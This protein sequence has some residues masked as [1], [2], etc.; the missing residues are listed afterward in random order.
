MKYLFF[1]QTDGRGHM[2]QAIT[3]KEKL[4]KNGHTIVGVVVGSDKNKKLP[5]FFTEQFACPF[6]DLES[7][8]F[9]STKD[10]KGVRIIASFF[11]T[12]YR[13]RPYL[14]SI[15]QVKKI[16]SSLQPDVIIN[17]YEPLAGN[18]Y[19]LFKDRRPM[20]CLGHQF[21]INHPALKNP[22]INFINKLFFRFYNYLTAGHRA[23][24]IALSFSKE[25]DLPKKNLFVCPPLIRG[26]I[27]N[28]A[29]S[30][31]NFILVY[32][33]TSGFSQ[34][35]ITWSNDHPNYQVEAFWDRH[36]Q[37]ETRLGENLVFHYLN[38]E[39]FINR[40]ST[41]SAY[42]A[43]AGFDS[44]AEAAYLQKSILMIPTKNHFEQ[45]SNAADAKRAG[46]AVSAKNFD[47]SL[48][49]DQQQKTHSSGALQTFKEWVDG[50][51]DKIINI[52]ENKKV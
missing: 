21:F 7:P 52:L 30:N 10:G 24:K 11:Y 13:L 1:V 23:V 50:Y 44:I 18:Y 26:A 4:E 45:K 2:T 47:L 31:D 22:E 20:F 25:A 42:V 5:A 43:T 3:L 17:F 35:I 15:W 46:I 39:K 49:A 38:G 9:L 34:E 27:K 36:E 37:E 48:I 32:I 6:F 19:R 29:A 8:K 14:A 41:C 51:D 28:S 16:V 40:L 12:I 33:L